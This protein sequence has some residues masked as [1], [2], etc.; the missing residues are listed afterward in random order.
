MVFCCSKCGLKLLY[1]NMASGSYIPL[2]ELV[3]QSTLMTW[4]N[5]KEHLSEM[6]GN[7]GRIICNVR[8][9][10]IERRWMNGNDTTSKRL[11]LRKGLFKMMDKVKIYKSP[12]AI[13]FPWL[14]KGSIYILKI[15]FGSNLT[16]WMMKTLHHRFCWLDRGPICQWQNDHSVSNV[17]PGV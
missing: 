1:G 15:M 7:E 16:T 8:W 12:T 6:S 10:S 2:M 5:H 3:S 14:E 13:Y 17:F 4:G 11:Q 9:R